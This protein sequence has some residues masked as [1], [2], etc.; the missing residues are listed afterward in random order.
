M[1]PIGED[2]GNETPD[3][4]TPGNDAPE[5]AF[6][7]VHRGSNVDDTVRPSFVSNTANDVIAG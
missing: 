3:A 2:Y 4:S 1:G 6:R 5:D 7:N